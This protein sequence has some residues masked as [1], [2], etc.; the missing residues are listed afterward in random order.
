MLSSS[1]KKSRRP[2]TKPASTRQVWKGLVYR[3]PHCDVVNAKILPRPQTSRYQLHS[4]F[5]GWTFK[6][7][8]KTTNLKVPASFRVFG[9]DLRG[10]GQDKGLKP[11]D[12]SFIQSFRAGPSRPRPRPR[13]QTSRHQLHSE[14]L[15]W[16]VEGKAKAFM[17]M[18]RAEN[19]IHSTSGSLTG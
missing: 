16:T 3:T 9:L 15:G 6:A 17:H 11:Q 8:A 4:E 18:A 2:W 7:K 14:F 10:Q 19:K 1:S 5:S 12:T 13:P